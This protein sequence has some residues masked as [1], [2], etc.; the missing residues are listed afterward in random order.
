MSVSPLVVIG[1]ISYS[2]S[3]FTFFNSEIDKGIYDAM[4]KGI[5]AAPTTYFNFSPTLMQY[6]MHLMFC[7]NHF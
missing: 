4:N 1:L 5:A 7:L 2:Q 3:G 6:D